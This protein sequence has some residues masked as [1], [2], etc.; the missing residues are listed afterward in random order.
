MVR[1]VN[2]MIDGRRNNLISR[3][4]VKLLWQSMAPSLYFPR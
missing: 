3:I 2:L 4:G 1:F